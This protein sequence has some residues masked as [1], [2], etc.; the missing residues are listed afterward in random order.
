MTSNVSL[1][2]FDPAREEYVAYEL[3]SEPEQRGEDRRVS[4]RPIHG[5]IRFE[6]PWISIPD[7]L[8]KYTHIS[9]EEI[10]F[11]MERAARRQEY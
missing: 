7:A 11:E 9:F 2:P 1:Y 5:Q 6:A 8:N 4:T 10:E 3:S